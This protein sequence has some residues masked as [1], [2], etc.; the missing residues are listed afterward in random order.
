MQPWLCFEWDTMSADYSAPAPSSLAIRP[1]NRED[2]EVVGKV[3]RTAFSMDSSW[4]DISR[5]LDESMERFVE[6]AFDKSRETPSCVVAQHGSRIIGVS[7]MDAEADSLNHLSSGPMILHEYRNRG[8]GSALLAASL[9]FLRSEGLAKVRGVTRANSTPARFIY[10]KFGS[11]QVSC[12]L[13]P[14]QVAAR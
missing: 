6:E 2:E 10:T 3:L 12:A 8:L 1:A 13:D 4:G 11:H 5:R 14:L 9:N 7:V